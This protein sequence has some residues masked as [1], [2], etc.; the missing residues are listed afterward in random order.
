MKPDRALGNWCLI[1]AFMV[2][3]MTIGGGHARTIGAGF[4]IQ[5][6]RPF[7]GFIPPTSAADWAFLFGLYQKTAVFQAHPISFDQ[8]K[9]LFWPMFIDR[10]WGR[11]MAL[12]FLIPFGY[13][14][15]KGRLRGK[16]A[17]W[18]L[19]I[20]GLG[21]F[22]ATWGWYMVHSAMQPGVLSPPPAW[23]GPHLG[24]AMFIFF[25]E[26]WTGLSFR[27]PAPTPIEGA[28]GLKNALTVCVVLIWCTIVFGAL[29]ATSNAITVFNS[30]PTMDGHWVPSGIFSLQ[31]F[32]LNFVENKATIQFFHRL[33]ATVTA[34]TVLG[35]A[36]S[37]LRLTLP[38]AM[39][40]LL[41]LLIGF[42]SL[43]YL[44]GMITIVLGNV[45]IG[46]IH[47]LNAVMLFATAITTRHKLRGA[48]S[49]PRQ[50]IHEA[51]A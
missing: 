26:I 36:F 7:T 32:G 1:L 31:P 34:L 22:Q 4:T 8:Y 49:T 10:C 39:R 43:Q 47:E 41:L 20:F 50:I 6:W 14:V 16:W 9:A 48:V 35:T 19:F 18:M 33:L 23:A 17:L 27:Q 29:V 44:L 11:L 46:Y 37:G 28:T 12:M 15:A 25:L 40:D 45:N 24:S 42:V 30:F 21:I 51:A 5:V 2:F 38:P 13:F 3:G